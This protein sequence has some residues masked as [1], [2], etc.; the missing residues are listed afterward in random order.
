MLALA[1]ASR[2]N[3]SPNGSLIA[4]GCTALVLLLVY[5]L[6]VLTPAGQQ[7]E[8]SLLDRDALPPASAP[9]SPLPGHDAPAPAPVPLG[10]QPRSAAFPTTVI[11]SSDHAAFAGVLLLVVPLVR[12]RPR[13]ALWGLATLAGSAAMATALVLVAVVACPGAWRDVVGAVGTTVAVLTAY[14]VQLAGWH[15]PS[16]IV[17]GAG[18]ALLCALLAAAPVPAAGDR[19]SA[20]ASAA[21]GSSVSARS[22]SEPRPSGGPVAEQDRPPDDAHSLPDRLTGQDLMRP[23]A[24]SI[25]TPMPELRSLGS[26]RAVREG[27]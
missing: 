26:L 27:A 6:G 19:P 5:V 9:A 1:S 12:R 22:W 17:M 23:S 7:L 10:E 20:R 16:D 8:N 2:V 3:G 18:V 14:F 11:L 15:R 25:R 24:R 21:R 13:Q 4:S